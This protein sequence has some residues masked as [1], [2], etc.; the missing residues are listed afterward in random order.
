MLTIRREQITIFEIESWRR[1]S[2]QAARHL[3]TYFPQECAALGES[4]LAAN[5]D[6]GILRARAHGLELTYDFLRYLNLSIV[7]GWDF[8]QSCAWASEILAKPELG[9]HTRMDL[10]SQQA[11]CELHWTEKET[12]E[13]SG[14]AD[15]AAPS[16]EDPI[17][18]D[19]LEDEE[20]GQSRDGEEPE[21]LQ[22]EPEE[23]PIIW[24]LDPDVDYTAH[25]SD[26][27][28]G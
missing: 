17:E 12:E 5:I 13:D 1:L 3:R 19:L 10:L 4:N 23:P 15:T 6:A 11:L 7:F 28:D 9:G 8:D 22:W 18:P 26:F 20:P 25:E 2:Q 27:R 24:E 14:T 21:P 16:V